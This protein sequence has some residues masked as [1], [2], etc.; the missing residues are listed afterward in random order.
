M[1]QQKDYKEKKIVEDAQK[2]RIVELGG[3]NFEENTEQEKGEVIIQGS[4]ARPKYQIL[5]SFG[6]DLGEFIAQGPADESKRPKYL[7]VKIELPRVVLK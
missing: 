2:N 1:K 6:V 7:I 3:T 4:I 5:H